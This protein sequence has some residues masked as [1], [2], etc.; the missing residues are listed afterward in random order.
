MSVDNMKIIYEELPRIIDMILL[1][2]NYS[3]HCSIYDNSF[4]DFSNFK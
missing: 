2:K 1:S 3:G 4:R